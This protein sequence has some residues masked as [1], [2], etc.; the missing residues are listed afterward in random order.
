MPVIKRCQ[1][2]NRKKLMKSNNIFSIESNYLILRSLTL[3]HHLDHL[4]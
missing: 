2:Y 1:S 3:L 4:V